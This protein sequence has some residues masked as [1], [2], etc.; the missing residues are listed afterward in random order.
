MTNN[1]SFMSKIRSHSPQRCGF[2]F[3]RNNVRLWPVAVDALVRVEG[4]IA[5]A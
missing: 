5:G 1:E 4:E 3:L 2:S